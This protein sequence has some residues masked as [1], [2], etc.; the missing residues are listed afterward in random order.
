MP[1]SQASAYISGA[2][3]RALAGMQRISRETLI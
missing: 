3:E 2:A 1:D